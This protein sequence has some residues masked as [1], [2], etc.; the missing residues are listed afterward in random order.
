MGKN[1]DLCNYAFEYARSHGVKLYYLSNN[2]RRVYRRGIKNI[3]VAGP[4]EFLSYIKYAD[5]VFTDSFHGTAF[6]AL[7]EKAFYCHITGK[8]SDERMINLVESLGIKNCIESQF[9]GRIPQ[10]SISN[11]ISENKDKVISYFNNIDLSYGID[12]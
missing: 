7:F 8:K 9:I 12:K 2:I 11:Y 3:Y 6:S 1:I 10:Y 4:D 5:Y